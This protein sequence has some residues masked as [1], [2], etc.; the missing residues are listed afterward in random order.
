MAESLNS[1]LDIIMN[2]LT[3]L[4]HKTAKIKKVMAGFH[5]DEAYVIAPSRAYYYNLRALCF[6]CNAYSG[7]ENL[8]LGYC[9]MMFQ[10]L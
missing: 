3:S 6:L 1:K 9:L 4:S 7:L 8:N 2:V 5:N 10:L